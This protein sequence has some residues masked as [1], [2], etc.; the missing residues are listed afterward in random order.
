MMCRRSAAG[1]PMLPT[2]T[3][4]AVGAVSTPMKLIPL[5]IAVSFLI[6]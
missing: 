6:D 2:P 1:D 3:A 4:Y 5:F